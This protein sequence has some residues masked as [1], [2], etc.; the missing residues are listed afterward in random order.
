M[1]NH[2]ALRIIR[3]LADG[4]DPY[5]GEKFPPESPYQNAATVRALFTAA[6]S[7]E[8]AIKRERSRSNL[9]E[10]AG[11][12]W[13]GEESDR[14]AHHYDNGVSIPELAKVHCRTSGAIR[15]RLVKLGR[16][17]PERDR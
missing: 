6:Q 1:E 2:E 11:E 5:T 8:I 13:S 16:T 17:V 14:L 10:R 4:V 15:S 12:P 3:I 9:P 7:L